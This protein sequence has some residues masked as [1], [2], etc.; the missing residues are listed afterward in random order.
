MTTEINVQFADSSEATIVSVFAGPQ[1][2]EAY[3][4]QG[5]IPSSDA[6]YQ[7]WYSALPAFIKALGGIVLPDT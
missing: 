6:R 1:D 5:T 4:N 3:P 7:T 2:P